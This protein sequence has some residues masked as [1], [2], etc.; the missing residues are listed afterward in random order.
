MEKPPKPAL[1]HL[2]GRNM[3]S[4]KKVTK[5][6]SEKTETVLLSEVEVLSACR[7]NDKLKMYRIETK[8]ER[9][10]LLKHFAVKNMVYFKEQT[11]QE[12]AKVVLEESDLSEKC[13]AEQRVSNKLDVLLDMMIDGESLEAVSKAQKK[14]PSKKTKKVSKK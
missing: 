7:I 10:V 12:L 5:R 2:K 1:V 11:M 3:K 8:G 4:N 9:Y 6:K 13:S 14:K